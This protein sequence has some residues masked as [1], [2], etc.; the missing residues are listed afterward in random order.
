[1]TAADPIPAPLTPERLSLNQVTLGPKVDLRTAV[2]AIARAGFGGIAPWRG[3][4]GRPRR[5]DGGPSDP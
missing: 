3:A 1:M 5:G 2:E 4:C